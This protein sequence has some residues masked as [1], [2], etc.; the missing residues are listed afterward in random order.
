MPATVIVVAPAAAAAVSVVDVSVPAPLV[1]GSPNDPHGPAPYAPPAN[2]FDH[3][4]SSNP[5]V[6]QPACSVV[7]AFQVVS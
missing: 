5:A 7:L 3:D 4:A 6:F 2:A 1:L